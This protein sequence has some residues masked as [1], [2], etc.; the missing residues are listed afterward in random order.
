[1]T[2]NDFNQL[3]Q[4]FFKEE[5]RL[6]D[7]KGTEYIRGSDDRLA[8]FKEIAKL[9]PGK[10]GDPKIVWL[11][12]F[13]K[14]IDSIINYIREGREFSEETIFSRIHDARNYLVILAGIIKDMEK[15]SE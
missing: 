4:D 1:M 13:M 6:L 10:N 12:F 2:S 9:L 7:V 14:H 3:V 11:V 8:N 15:S 5:L